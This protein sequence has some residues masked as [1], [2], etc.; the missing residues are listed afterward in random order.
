MLTWGAPIQDT[1]R[2]RR[3]H[4]WWAL[5]AVML[6]TFTSTISSTIVANAT[7]TIVADLNGFHLYGWIFTAYMLAS[8]VSVPFFGSLSDAYGRRPLALIGIGLFVVGSALAGLAPSMLWLI[9]ARV[10]AGIGGGAMVSLSAAGVADIFS[11][12][13]RGKWQAL[14]MSALALSSMLGPT[15]GGTITGH[16]GWRWVFFAVVPLGLVAWTLVGIVLPRMRVTSRPRIDLRGGVLF[17]GGL[18]GI[19]LG[20]TWGGTSYPWLSWQEG[21][22]FG[23]GLAILVLFVLVERT[24]PAPILSP[25]LFRSRVFML[26]VVIS[27]LIVGSMFIT[28]TFMPLFRSSRARAATS[29]SPW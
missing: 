4:R 11:P 16:F 18:I 1:N 10:V 14:V 26:S 15:L 28:I 19:L 3:D 5:A 13:E 20:C 24:V 8:T 21:V 23:A 27:F 12:R 17:V 2:I 7:P 9:A 22:S 25:H 29:R 6:M